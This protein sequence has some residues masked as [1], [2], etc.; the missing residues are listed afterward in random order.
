MVW[1][2]LLLALVAGMALPIQAGVNKDLA[3]WV[4]GPVRASAVSF[5]IGTLALVLLSLVLWRVSPAAR[6]VGDAPWWVWA[7]GIF[8]AFYVASTVA[9]APRL[10]AVTLVAA[11][12]AGQALAS[13][14]LDHFGILFPEHAI[15][16]GRIAGV[17]LLAAGVVLVRV[18]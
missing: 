14:V 15:S 12:V 5:A 18:F 11:I 7:G 4:G 9:A 3:T 16:P 6:A 1:A 17:V 2:F 8:G 10:G 13:L